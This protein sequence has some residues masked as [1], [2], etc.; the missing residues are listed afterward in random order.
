MLDTDCYSCMRPPHVVYWGAAEEGC[1][2]FEDYSLE[3]LSN[4][5]FLVFRGQLGLGPHLDVWFLSGEVAGGFL[6]V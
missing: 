6:F 5:C 4:L 1:V 3:A 2:A